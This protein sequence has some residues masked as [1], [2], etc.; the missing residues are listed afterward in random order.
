VAEDT[1]YEILGV[2]RDAT[3]EEIRREYHRLARKYHPD[4][5][6]TVPF[7]RQLQHAYE[8]LSDPDKRREYD[9]FLRRPSTSPQES[10]PP[11]STPTVRLT[12]AVV[13]LLLV[14]I[15]LEVTHD[16]VVLVIVGLGT[17]AWWQCHTR[18]GRERA[19]KVAQVQEAQRAWAARQAAEWERGRRDAERQAQRQRATQA[20]EWW[21]ADPG[22][23]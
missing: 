6:G 14:G 3:S 1:L 17:A 23:A 20:E 8:V 4:G 21:R 10:P 12:S 22:S 5:G 19:A 13:V 11:P 2:G 16:V 7:F 18:Y 15:L 9:E